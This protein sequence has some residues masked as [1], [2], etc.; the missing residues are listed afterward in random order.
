[1]SIINYHD[2]NVACDLAPNLV[3]QENLMEWEYKITLGCGEVIHGRITESDD[4][5]LIMET[6]SPEFSSVSIRHDCFPGNWVK[7]GGSN[8]G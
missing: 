7:I 5:N 4:V 3:H 6:D 1:M 8:A 2:A